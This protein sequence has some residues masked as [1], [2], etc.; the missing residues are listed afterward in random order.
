MKYF[1]T[2][3]LLLTTIS[4]C[5]SDKYTIMHGSEKWIVVPAH[6]PVSIEPNGRTGAPPAEI[7]SLIPPKDHS[8]DT[9]ADAMAVATLYTTK[10]MTGCVPSTFIPTE[11]TGW[12]IQLVCHQKIQPGCAN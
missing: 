12:T 2:T 6:I 7:V 3:V 5:A 9:Q 1:V 8:G 11:G 4:G 10:Y